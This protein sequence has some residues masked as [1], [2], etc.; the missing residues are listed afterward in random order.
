MS[1]FFTAF[2]DEFAERMGA[3]ATYFVMA[4]YAVVSML[5]VFFVQ[6]FLDANEASLV[7]FFS[8]QPYI[9]ALFAPALA[10]HAWRNEIHL[11]NVD[12]VLNAPTP[13]WMLVTAKWLAFTCA[14]LIALIGAAG[15][16]WITV[17]VLGDPDN[18]AIALGFFACAALLAA[19]VAVSI[20]MGSFASSGGQAF[21]YGAA[22]IA[23]ALA[24]GLAPVIHLVHTRISENIGELFALFSLES[25]FERARIGIAE[26]R[27]LIFIVTFTL[28]WLGLAS[29]WV[30]SKKGA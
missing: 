16:L 2:G 29:L 25:Y 19:F 30:S 21:L 6:D 22:A 26:A 23:C 12:L 3:P 10:R 14:G 13:I 17:N 1:L 20:A 8:T 9:L 18:G 4:G 11:G 24:L 27:G 5:I 28:L 7:R 15:P